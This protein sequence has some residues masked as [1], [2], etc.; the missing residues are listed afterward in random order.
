MADGEDDEYML[1]VKIQIRRLVDETNPETAKIRPDLK[2]HI[3][4]NNMLLSQP[5]ASKTRYQHVHYVNGKRYRGDPVIY[6]KSYHLRMIEEGQV[7]TIGPFGDEDLRKFQRYPNHIY[8]KIE[9]NQDDDIIFPQ[10]EL[11]PI[12]TPNEAKAE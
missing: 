7:R 12:L 9:S 3:S 8:I 10:L 5:K 11:T 2:I 1:P 6:D 4:M